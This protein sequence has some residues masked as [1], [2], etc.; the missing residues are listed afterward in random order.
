[1]AEDWAT[2][3]KSFWWGNHAEYA[4][5][6]GSDGSASQYGGGLG[7]GGL[8]DTPSSVGGISAWAFSGTNPPYIL[9]V[10]MRGVFEWRGVRRD[11][12]G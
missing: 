6:G 12:R 8:C 2:Y 4:P 3:K 11:V 9:F 5:E 10:G 7:V 1:M